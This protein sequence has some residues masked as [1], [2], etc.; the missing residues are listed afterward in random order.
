MVFMLA[1]LLFPDT[2]RKAQEEIDRVIGSDRLPEMKDLPRLPYLTN[3][4][5]ELWRWQPILPLG[6]YMH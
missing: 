5:Q 3:L 1:M 6:K 4:V 2:Q